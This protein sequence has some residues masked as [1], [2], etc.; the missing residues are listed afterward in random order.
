MRPIPALVMVPAALV[1]PAL[2]YAAEYLTV[3]QAQQVIFPEADRFAD[4]AVELSDAQR[5]AIEQKF[6]NEIAEIYG[7]RA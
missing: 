2:A 3:S 4:A 1:A 7:A 6:V 5:K